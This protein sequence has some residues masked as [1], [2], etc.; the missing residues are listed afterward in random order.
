MNDVNDM[1][2]LRRSLQRPHRRRNGILELV[3]LILAV[4]FGIAAALWMDQRATIPFLD[5]RSTSAA[6]GFVMEGRPVHHRVGFDSETPSP[7][8][9]GPDSVELTA[10]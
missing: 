1:H 8:E 10:G 4:I 5:V 3:G 7:G 9:A 2:D 6:F